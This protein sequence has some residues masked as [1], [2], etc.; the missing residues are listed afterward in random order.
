MKL[1]KVKEK[2]PV[3]DNR[4]ENF[5]REHVLDVASLGI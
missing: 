1:N 2:Q 5:N 4:L 3:R